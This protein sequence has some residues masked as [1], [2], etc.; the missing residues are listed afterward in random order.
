MKNRI[1]IFL[2]TTKARLKEAIGLKL[3]PFEDFM[4]EIGLY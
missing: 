2:V 4:I 1:W 3:T